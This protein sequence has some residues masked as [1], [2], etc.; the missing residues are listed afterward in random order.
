MGGA[1]PP[2]NC[3]PSWHAQG[4]INLCTY[5]PIIITGNQIPL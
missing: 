3:M 1:A 5:V 2:L 4:E